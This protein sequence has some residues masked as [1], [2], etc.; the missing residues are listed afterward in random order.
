MSKIIASL[1][2]MLLFTQTSD[3]FGKIYVG[4]GDKD[5]NKFWNDNG[6]SLKDQQDLNQFIRNW[7]NRK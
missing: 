1:F 4:R 5:L 2:A 7:Q 6:V 3:A